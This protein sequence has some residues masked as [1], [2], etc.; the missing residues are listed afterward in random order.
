MTSQNVF[1]EIKLAVFLN[2]TTDVTEM[3]ASRLFSCESTGATNNI[4]DGSAPFRRASEPAC[5]ILEL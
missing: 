3:L 5:T 1:C 4:N 2:T